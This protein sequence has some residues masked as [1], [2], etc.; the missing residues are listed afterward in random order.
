MDETY[1]DICCLFLAFG[2]LAIQKFLGSVTVNLIQIGYERMNIRGKT[3]SN[4]YYQIVEMLLNLSP[5]CNI[6]NF[7]N[8]ISF[9]QLTHKTNITKRVREPNV[10]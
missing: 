10:R 1:G 9:V 5:I 7:L 6:L 4:K 2:I 8:K 3:T